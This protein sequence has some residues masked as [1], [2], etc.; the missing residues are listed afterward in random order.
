M[1]AWHEHL[2]LC[3]WPQETLKQ[4]VLPWVALTF[5]VE[6]NLYTVCC[7]LVLPHP[8]APERGRLFTAFSPGLCWRRAQQAEP[9]S[10]FAWPH[11]QEKCTEDFLKVLVCPVRIYWNT[12]FPSMHQQLSMKKANGKRKSKDIEKSDS[13]LLK[14]EEQ[15]SGKEEVALRIRGNP[16]FLRG[17]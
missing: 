10:V 11:T 5:F 17:H 15:L 8:T 9:P 6:S 4:K 16:R 7:V 3:H 13:Y 2:Y 12:G 14:Q 1:S